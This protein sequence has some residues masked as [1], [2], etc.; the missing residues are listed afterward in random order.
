MKIQSR[1]AA[2]HLK[3]E[4]TL[5]NTTALVDQV[6]SGGRLSGIYVSDDDDVD[7]ALFFT[8][9]CVVGI[10]DAAQIDG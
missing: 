5:V 9:V 6:T 3:R 10:S 7:V 4:L 1:F 8:P 2:E